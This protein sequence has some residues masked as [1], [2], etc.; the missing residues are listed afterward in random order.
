[1][2]DSTVSA[3]ND[4]RQVV[5]DTEWSGNAEIKQG[6]QTIRGILSLVRYKQKRIVRRV[7][8]FEISGN[9][10]MLQSQ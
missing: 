8:S 7:R 6:K 9:R 10:H 2:S 4:V 1:M 5:L 3:R